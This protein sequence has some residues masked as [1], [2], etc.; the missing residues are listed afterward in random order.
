MTAPKADP[1]YIRYMETFSA[2]TL[3]TR[4]CTACQH[5]QPCAVGAPIH[6][7]FAK[8]QDAYQARQSAKRRT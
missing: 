2:S 8:A 1:V 6:T 5:G 7:V 4:D 3:H